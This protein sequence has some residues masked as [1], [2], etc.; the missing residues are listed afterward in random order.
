MFFDLL[1]ALVGYTGNVIVRKENTFNS[2][3]TRERI[4]FQLASDFPYISTAERRAI[5]RISNIGALYTIV[6]EFACGSGFSLHSKKSLYLLALQ[7]AVDE[8]LDEYRQLIASYEEEAIHRR[9]QN[10]SLVEGELRVWERRFEDLCMFF[11]KILESK[12]QNGPELITLLIQFC[13]SGSPDTASLCMRLLKKC[14]KVLL[15]QLQTWLYYGELQDPHEEFFLKKKSKD[16]V[17]QNEHSSLSLAED[18]VIAE[19]NLTPLFSHVMVKDILFIG[20]VVKALR[21]SESDSSQVDWNEL[22]AQIDNLRSL[23]T[24]PLRS[25]LLESN[26]QLT[27]QWA[28]KQLMRFLFRLAWWK[29]FEFLRQSFLLGKGD[30]WSHFLHDT[31]DVLTIPPVNVSKESALNTF[32]EKSLLKVFFEV[33][34]RYEILRF[35]RM[36]FLASNSETTTNLLPLSSGWSQIS[37]SYVPRNPLHIL[38]TTKDLEHYS[39]VFCIVFAIT[40]VRFQMEHCW[41]I[42]RNAF[43]ECNRT[44]LVKNRN[45]FQLLRR[46]SFLVRSLEEFYQIDLIEESF[47][48]FM[49]Q[50]KAASDFD[51]VHLLH[52]K[53]INTLAKHTLIYSSSFIESLD[54]LLQVFREYCT[55]IQHKWVQDKA[56]QMLLSIERIQQPINERITAF[57]QELQKYPN[58][59]ISNRLL[60]RMDFNNFYSLE[61][62]TSLDLEENVTTC[63]EEDQSDNE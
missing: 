44:A 6:D 19:E 14:I 9:L 18:I 26:I 17:E 39:R 30:L 60:K 34:F 54:N 35:E 33:D 28:S 59:P 5:D 37:L 12:R 42:F 31:C 57:L 45:M 11:D 23:E 24:Q 32:L 48:S 7:K 21:N 27:R 8:I 62:G 10:L 40:H 49:K 50:A 4:S 55:Y 41:L 63:I 56:T 15:I 38:M 43:K 25:L 58:H 46:C 16:A 13:K 2:K 1:Y 20:G 61:K 36:N 53:Y 29:E 22:E 52:Q 3:R 47:G 51:S